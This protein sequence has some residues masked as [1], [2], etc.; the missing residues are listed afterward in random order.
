MPIGNPADLAGHRLGL[1]SRYPSRDRWE[2]LHDDGP[3]TMELKPV[4]RS[5]SVHL[6]RDYAVAG[7]GVVCIPT[8]VAAE[9]ILAGQLTVLL[10]AYQLS[11]FWLSAVFPHTQ[12][13]TLKLRLF[14]EVIAAAF[15]G[16]PPWDLALAAR[17]LL[18]LVPP[19]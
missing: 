1:Y 7:A 6:L 18:R 3:V 5:N 2:F 9:A 8:V 17:G 19:D 10:P 12:R 13:H 16:P 4:L 15:S 11:H 14:L